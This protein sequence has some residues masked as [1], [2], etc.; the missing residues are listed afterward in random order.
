[1][2]APLQAN[3]IRVL[4]YE[5]S[6]SF[7]NGCVAF[8]TAE[9]AAIMSKAVGKPVR[10]QIMRWDEH[11]WTHYAPAIMYDMRAGVDANG[12][13][14]AYEATGFGQGGTS[15]LH[16]PRARGPGRR[17]DPDRERDPDQGA[18][19]A[20]RSRRTCSPWMKVANTNYKLINKPI[21]ST[22]GIFHSGPLRAPGAQQTTFADAQTI[23]MLA[24][25]ANM[26][27]LAFRLQNM[28]TDSTEP[29]LVGGAAGGGDG[30]GL[31][32][33]GLRLEPEQGEHRHRPRHRQQPSRRRL[34]G[35][36]RRHPGEQEDRQDP[37]HASLCG[38]GLRLRGEPGP[39]LQP[40]DRQRD[41]G[42]EPCA[43]GRGHVQQE[44][45]HSIDWV[46]YPIL[47]FKD[48]PKVTNVLVQRTDQPSLG[49]G[50]PVTCPI[51]GRDRQRVLRRNRRAPARGAHDTAGTRSGDAL[52]AAGHQL[53]GIVQT[54]TGEARGPGTMPG[55]GFSAGPGPY[56][57]PPGGA[58]RSGAAPAT[59]E[60]ATTDPTAR[61]I[62]VED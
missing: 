8:D 20:G 45:G 23:D 57:S 10:L 43:L 42:H 38:S 47:R 59:G 19:A 1:M 14:V 2:L 32:A 13:I 6:G 15:H 48:A 25:A 40:D 7:G 51:V 52:K 16:R 33:V 12:N 54:R 27:S 3:Q 29:A 5:G 49:S 41:P 55:P 31:E 56:G 50:E 30:G 60:E 26:D 61:G 21:D 18:T 46:T 9:S 44:P 22:M 17:S 4:F 39:D 53:D 36:R 58:G 34:R 24:V 35:G 11:G 28:Q 62:G 37:R